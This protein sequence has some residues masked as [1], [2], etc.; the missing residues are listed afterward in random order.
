MVIHGKAILFCRVCLIYMYVY[1]CLSYFSPLSIVTSTIVDVR[2]QKRPGCFRFSLS[3]SHTTRK[4]AS[5]THTAHILKIPLPPKYHTK[6]DSI[7]AG[8]NTA[9]GNHNLENVLNDW[10]RTVSTQKQAY[11]TTAS[12]RSTRGQNESGAMKVRPNHGCNAIV[13]RT[14]VCCF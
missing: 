12:Q 3:T 8:T 10:Q 13:P 5:F 11:N 7:P 9:Q 6:S 4:S 2:R 1:L 14:F